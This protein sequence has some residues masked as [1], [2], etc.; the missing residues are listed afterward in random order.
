MKSKPTSVWKRYQFCGG[1]EIFG[2]QCYIDEITEIVHCNCTKEK[3]LKGF[4]WT[5]IYYF[6]QMAYQE[7]I[8]LV[9]RYRKDKSNRTQEQA[10]HDIR[11][12]ITKSWKIL[13]FSKSKTTLTL[14]NFFKVDFE[15]SSMWDRS[16]E[17]FSARL[18]LW[19]SQKPGHFFSKSKSKSKNQFTRTV[20][21]LQFFWTF[22]FP[23][24]TRPK[25][26]RQKWFVVFYS[27]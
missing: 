7:K 12:D 9:D 11:S 2:T 6:F 14:R 1:I 21:W 20:L 18:W 22:S 5:I 16:T 23:S 19:K 8:H 17:L 13:T 4:D 15:K 3:N 24:K 25:I 26:W 10:W 27:S